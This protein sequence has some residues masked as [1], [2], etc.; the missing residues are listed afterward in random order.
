MKLLTPIM[1]ITI[2]AFAAAP[3]VYA[4]QSPR[5]EYRRA[6]IAAPASTTVGKVESISRVS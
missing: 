5:C 4:G 1:A 2:L 6:F 3:C